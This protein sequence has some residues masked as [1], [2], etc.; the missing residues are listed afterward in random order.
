MV[1][2]LRL[3]E[4]QIKKGGHTQKDRQKTDILFY[5]Y[6]RLYNIMLQYIKVNR[7]RLVYTIVNCLHV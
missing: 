4:T 1:S 5:Y 6:I 2:A 7:Q 3:A